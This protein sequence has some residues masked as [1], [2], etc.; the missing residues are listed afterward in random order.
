M[1]ANDCM[2]CFQELCLRADCQRCSMSVCKFPCG[3]RG[4]GCAFRMC[5]GCST[6][7][8]LTSERMCDCEDDDCLFANTF[9]PR[10]AA[11]RKTVRVYL[12]DQDAMKPQVMPWN[13]DIAEVFPVLTRKLNNDRSGKINDRSGKH[14]SSDLWKMSACVEEERV[15]E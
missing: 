6:R 7:L 12:K 3:P 14:D 11:C 15:S 8:T 9:T 5:K 10:C 2:V 4:N 1:E 13:R